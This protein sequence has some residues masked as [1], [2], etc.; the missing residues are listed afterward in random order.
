[1]R[2]PAN[3]RDDAEI[4]SDIIKACNDKPLEE[5][6][7]ILIGARRESMKHPPL[8]GFRTTNREY[9][10]KLRKWIGRGHE[11]FRHMPKDFNPGMLFDPDFVPE[12]DDEQGPEERAFFGNM[13]WFRQRLDEIESADLGRDRRAGYLQEW[14]AISARELCERHGL[15]L[16]YSSP[17]SAY[18]KTAR[19]FFEAMTGKPPGKDGEGLIMRAC[20][21][22][23][24]VPICTETVEK[25]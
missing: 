15:P 21:A 13:A 6:V 3:K 2:A 1:M 25:I 22:M 17:T 23:R 16:A 4:I 9:V 24:A 8:A 14:A 7:T 12:N 5:E 10:A 20:R 18:C 11:L 19:L